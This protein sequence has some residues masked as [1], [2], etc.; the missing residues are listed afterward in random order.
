M[1]YLTQR[2][3][4]ED[5]FASHKV[6]FGKSGKFCLSQLE[7]RVLLEPIM[8]RDHKYFLKS[9]NLL[10]SLP[11]KKKKNYL[12]QMLIVSKSRNPDKTYF[13]KKY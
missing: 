4:I 1:N 10:D 12:A 13:Q 11:L 6:S 7:D 9:Y 2:L 5:D 3:P 8:S